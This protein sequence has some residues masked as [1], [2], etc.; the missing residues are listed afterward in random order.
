MGAGILPK[1]SLACVC[2]LTMG[3]Q[4]TCRGSKKLEH[5]ACKAGH[6]NN[7]SGKR[8]QAWGAWPPWRPAFGHHNGQECQ[9]SRKIASRWQWPSSAVCILSWCRIKEGFLQALGCPAWE[10]AQDMAAEA[11][12]ICTPSQACSSPPSIQLWPEKPHCQVPVLPIYLSSAGSSTSASCS[13]GAANVFYSVFKTPR[14]GVKRI[15]LVLQNSG[16][17]S[18]L[19]FTP[20]L[21]FV[22]Y[23]ICTIKFVLCTSKIV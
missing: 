4:H 9:I 13:L 2:S 19:P 17:G 20:S 14:A 15:L 23:K 11:T 7:H 10:G 6:Y 21:C 3:Q 22:L 5:H 12:A 18:K 16:L 8:Q 1:V